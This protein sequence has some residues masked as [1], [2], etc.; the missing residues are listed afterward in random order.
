MPARK[1]NSETTSPWDV[2][3]THR[4]VG[5]TA[6]LRDLGGTPTAD[7]RTITPGRVYRAEALVTRGANPLCTPWEP[8]HTEA[9]RALGVRTVIDLR[10]KG[11]MDRAASAWPE[12]TGAAC[13]LLPIEEGGEGDTN[14]VQEIRTGARTSFTAAD[15]AEYYALTLRRRGPEFGGALRILADPARTPVLVHCAAGK[16]RTGLLVA[17]LLEALGVPREVVVAD[18]ALTGVLRPNRV[19]AYAHLFEGVDLDAIALLFD[20]PATAMDEA[21]ASLDAEFGSVTGFLAAQCDV[22]PHHV[23]ALRAGLLS[24]S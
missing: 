6:N 21:L 13:V 7:G 2:R 10:S 23:D 15:M 19:Q 4:P 1:W 3:S 24:P 22:T 16:D 9:Y 8:D 5:A 12:A 14:Y 20:S 17:L 18:Y 11:E